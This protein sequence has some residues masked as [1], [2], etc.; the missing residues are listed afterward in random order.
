MQPYLYIFGNKIP[1]YAFF[2]LVGFAVG[3]LFLFLRNRKIKTDS[4][5]NVSVAYILA[6]VG[7]FFGGKTFYMFLYLPQFLPYLQSGEISVLDWFMQSGLVFYGGFFGII[8]FIALYAKCVKVSMLAYINLLL[9][10]LP[11]AH[12]FGRVGCFMTGCCWGMEIDGGIVYHESLFAPNDVPLL[13]IQ[14]IESACLLGLFVLMLFYEKRQKNKYGIIVFYMIGYGIIRFV[15]EFFRGDA[16]RG[17]AAE[18]STSQWVSIVLI[19]LATLIFLA[20]K[21]KGN[22]KKVQA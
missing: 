7:S 18:L 3:Y 6:G 20:E 11:L 8:A 4:L 22:N 19:G 12:A 16:L 2:I 15:L 10:V 9:P 14:L 5:E 21:F 17:I 1:S 13:P